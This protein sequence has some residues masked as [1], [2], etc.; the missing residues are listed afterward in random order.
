MP[1]QQRVTHRPKQCPAAPIL[2]TALLGLGLITLPGIGHAEGIT[3]KIFGGSA[4]DELAPRQP[5]DEQK[6]IQQQVI[7]GFLKANPDVAAVEWDAQGPQ[8]DSIQRVMTA[9]LANQEMDLIACPAFYTNGAYVRRKL[10]MPITDKIKPFQDRIDAA[11]LGAFTVNGQVY[12]VPI[13]TLSTST[14]FYNVDLFQKLAIP[15]PP[16]YDDLKA[17]VP[18]FKTA[19]VIPLLHQGSNTVMWPM[20]YFETFSQASGDPVGKTQ[21]N[22][23]GTAKF[24][25]AP[26][27]E[28]FKLIKQWVDD[29]ILSKD[30]LSVD[31]DGMRAA[32]AAGK[33]AMY[34][35]GTWEIPSLQS[36]V[37]DFKWGVFAF[38]KMDGTP[39]APGHG[40]GADNG[41]CVAS[42]I[43]PEKL[44]AAVKF[45][46]YLT[47]PEV[48]TLY[49]APEQPIAAS[50]KGVPQVDDAYAVELRKQ[51][52]PNTI[53]FLDW[54]WP[55]EVASAT[56]SAIAGIVGGTTTP[57]DAAASIQ[58]IFDDLKAQGSWPPK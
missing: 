22:L 15:V 27:V 23:E 44:D 34:Y 48:A 53:K 29:G 11:A 16:T 19:G 6:K 5:P 56:S 30:S 54:I 2:A 21:K 25:D 50:I 49:L 8:T 58:T 57:E 45:I 47:R 24:T 36:S 32:F 28:G 35:G 1:L 38:P 33:S 46:E 12:G 13:S 51:A 18:K 42:S 3:L 26:D 9:K 55:S 39:G 52:F 40:G 20:W 43:P 7:D 37:K 10:V 4:L 41:M 17:A 14:I 31:Q